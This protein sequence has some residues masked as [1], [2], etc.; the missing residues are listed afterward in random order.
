MREAKIRKKRKEGYRNLISVIQNTVVHFYRKKKVLESRKLLLTCNTY[1]SFPSSC[2][3]CSPLCRLR[4]WR[5]QWGEPRRRRC[6]GT[7]RRIVRDLKF[8]Y[9]FGMCIFSFM[10]E[11]THVHC[12]CLL[13]TLKSLEVS[14]HPVC[15]GQ[16]LFAEKNNS[17]NVQSW[18]RTWAIIYVQSD[19]KVFQ[20]MDI[21]FNYIFYPR[22]LY[23]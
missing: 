2:C 21:T 12:S 10:C 6:D 13:Y 22:I 23:V 17:S 8:Q 11:D 19:R 7:R 16:P 3:C 14:T 1:R 15:K 5:L 4:P 20:H 9:F 18:S